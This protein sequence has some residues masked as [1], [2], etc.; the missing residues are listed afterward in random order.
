[1][2]AVFAML[3]HPLM[4]Q[5]GWTL[6]HSL[7]QGALVGIVFFVVRFGLRRRSADMRYLAGCL[8]LVALVAAPLLT[9]LIARASL[10]ASGPGD[11]VGAAPTGAAASVLRV[12]GL[13][14]SFGGNGTS[15]SLERGADFFARLQR[16]DPRDAFHHLLV[17]CRLL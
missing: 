16:H 14:R 8:C 13:G 2:N 10:P 3:N 7:W 17:L 4:R 6:L 5:V 1:M 12:A 15:W 9:L 11:F